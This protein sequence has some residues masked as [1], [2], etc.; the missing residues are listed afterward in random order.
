MT[1]QKYIL[2]IDVGTTALKAVLFTSDGIQKASA[3]QEYELEKPSINIVEV[4]AELYW[5]ALV[6]A[7]D[8]ILKNSFIDP[9]Q[10]VS[11]GVT[12]QG[13]TLILLDSNGEPLR[14]AIVWLDNRAVAEAKEINKKFT[15]DQVYRITGQHEIVPCW[16][17][18]KILWI[19]NNEL[20]VFSKVAKFLMVEDYLIY[21]LTG[22]FAT[23]H[24]LNPS[25][26]YYDIKNL[27]WWKEMVKF[28]EITPKQLPKLLYSGEVVGEITAKIGLSTKTRVTVAPIDQI[29]GA[30]GAGNIASGMITET[31]GSALAICATLDRLEYDTQKQ[32]GIY[33]HAQKGTYALLPWHPTAGMVYRWFRDELGGGKSYKELDEQAA[34]IPPGSD[35]L[36]V[37]PS[38][39]KGGAFIGL[40]LAHKQA[41]IVRAIFESVAFM[42]RDNLELLENMGVKI[43]EV[44]SLGGASYSKLWTQIKAD[45]LQKNIILM[46]SDETTCLGVA[47]LSSVGAGIYKDIEKAKNKMVRIKKIVKPNQKHASIYNKSFKKYK[48]RKQ[49]YV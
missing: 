1:K 14:K 17:A 2:A 31:T 11:V 35:D 48:E 7:I 36:T 40:T 5:E 39:S 29:A 12:S 30:V 20:E 43:K 33:L 25:T 46:D 44:H 21:R 9:E 37:L 32:V 6:N 28:L 10:I 16:T 23:D 13:E 8:K 3:I 27:C 49:N 26:L 45:V 4:A 24:A 22:K 42:L 41:H 19:R 38:F 34:Q 47:V 18:S 15:L